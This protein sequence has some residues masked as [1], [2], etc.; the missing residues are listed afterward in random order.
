MTTVG[1]H[2]IEINVADLQQSL[3]FYRLLQSFFNAEST[4]EEHRGAFSWKFADFYLWVN[5]VKPR[6]AEADYHRKRVGLDHLAFKVDSQQV[7]DQLQVF[8]MRHEIP[9]LYDAGFYGPSYYAVYF[10][11]PD[12]FK[13]EFGAEVLR[14]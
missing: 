6:F 3:D 11:A 2:H 13:L 10:E 5:Q 4:I 12:R 9:I 1:I 8:L 14:S 7:V